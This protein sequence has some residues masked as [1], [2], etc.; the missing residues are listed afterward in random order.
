MKNFREK[1]IQIGMFDYTRDSWMISDRIAPFQTRNTTYIT[2]I[3]EYTIP[4]GRIEY[5]LCDTTTLM[6]LI[7]IFQ[8]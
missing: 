3:S 5:W 4:I 8:N 7:Q 6:K 2:T 1:F